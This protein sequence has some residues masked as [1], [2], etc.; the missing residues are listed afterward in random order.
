MNHALPR[1]TICGPCIARDHDTVIHA[2]QDPNLWSML[3]QTTTCD[4]VAEDY[5]LCGAQDLSSESR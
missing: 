5:N 1:T 4:T 3:A 2:C